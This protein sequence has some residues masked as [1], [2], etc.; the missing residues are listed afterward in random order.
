MS[1]Y[2]AY[3]TGALLS[4]LYQK[5]LI[6]TSYP[7]T[8]FHEEHQS[9]LELFLDSDKE[10]LQNYSE[11]DAQSISKFY[12]HFTEKYKI[13]KYYFILSFNI[14]TFRDEIILSRNK[15]NENITKMLLE[16]ENLKSKRK[17]LI[18]SCCQSSEILTKYYD[19]IILAFDREDPNTISQIVE[20]I[21]VV[22]KNDKNRIH[23]EM[24]T[25][26]IFIS[27][28]TKDI[29]LAISLVNLLRVCYQLA[30]SEIRCTSA[31]GYRLPSGSNTSETLLSEIKTS[32]IFIA[33]LTS[34]SVNSAYVLFEM[35]ARW[36][37]G[38]SFIPLKTRS[39]NFSDISG[40]I[41][42][43]LN[44]LD[45]SEENQVH[46][47]IRELGELLGLSTYPDAYMSFVK[48]VIDKATISTLA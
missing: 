4:F 21:L 1:D 30:P 13:Y 48:P 33:L 18:F 25:I 12:E 7:D 11:L 43:N 35:G 29:D 5:I 2:Q 15:K 9:V 32:A 42:S 41:L 3:L 37:L 47:F 26:K 17:A 45:L 20:E 24:N 39:L 6:R 23:T 46:Q 10:M 8:D 38:L 14:S 40:P 31:D 34:N 44:I 27:H 36:G 22:L 28:S 16:M 19:R